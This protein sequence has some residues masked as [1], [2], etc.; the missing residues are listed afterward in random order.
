[1]EKYPQPYIEYLVHFHGS[2]DYFECHEIMEEFWIE[3]NHDV[4]WLALIQ[5]AVAVYHERQ[6]NIDGGLR[7]Y[8]K[9]LSHLR[10]DRGLLNDLSI[11]QSDLEQLIKSRI[12]NMLYEGPYQPLDLPIIDEALIEQCKQLAAKRG[13]EWSSC[14]IEDTTELIYRH[15]LR[16]R[17]EVIQ[18]R[19]HS[20]IKKKKE[21]EEG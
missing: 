16:D 21:R 14:E 19:Q 8:R 2:R 1:M 18:A 11:H 5:I 6:K 7:L 17:S 20:L 15:K 9:V 13:W 4:K 10:N 3:N 12:K